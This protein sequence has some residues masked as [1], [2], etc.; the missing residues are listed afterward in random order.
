MPIKSNALSLYGACLKNAVFLVYDKHFQKFYGII[1][2]NLTKS[3][4][5]KV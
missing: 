2:S 5:L 3:T 4:Y 1:R